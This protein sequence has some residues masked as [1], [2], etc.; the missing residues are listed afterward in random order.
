MVTARDASPT[1]I[2]EWSVFYITIALWLFVPEIRRVIDWRRGGY[3]SISIIAILPLLAS[4]L[5]AIPV[6]AGGAWKRINPRLRT[7]FAVW[8]GVYFYGLVVAL[9][10]GNVVAGGYDFLSVVLPIF[11]GMWLASLGEQRDTI[12]RRVSTALLVLSIPISVYG[13]Y[14]YAVLPIW[15]SLW[16]IAS[17]QTSI[18]PPI[19]YSFR[20]FSTLNSDG[21]CASVLTLTIVM[22]L[23]RLRL[24][25][26]AWY[27]VFALNIVVL[28]LTLVR[29]CWIGLIIGLLVY[30]V[31]ERKRMNSMLGLAAIA[32]VCIGVAAMAPTILG[33][34]FDS[35][36]VVDRFNSFGSLQDDPSAND[37]VDTL[38]VVWDALRNPV[39]DGLGV[40]G[41]A[42]KLSSAD[43]IAAVLDNGY[44]AQL[45]EVG[46]LGFIGF[47]YVLV[48]T[49]GF[50]VL[51]ALRGSPSAAIS[52]AT[53]AVM[54]WIE[55]ASASH[56]GL[57]AFFFGCAIPL[58]F[59]R[60]SVEPVSRSKQFTAPMS[61]VR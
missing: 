28:V 23:W 3:S 21:P 46:V 5:F 24:K 35:K 20:I 47:L 13:L 11:P 60:R 48:S 55:V 56:I 36:G 25:H 52:A 51:N 19:P 45:V 7:I 49:F 54:L 44:I 14:Q 8:F 6:L 42:A 38:S 61:A 50:S 26:A 57:L 32:A 59:E 29:S 18:G 43:Q 1:R 16:M 17:K 33:S 9:L 40:T 12:L 41:V 30:L 37:R 22:N 31:V 39:G 4:A 15:D 10:N 27:P 53:L 34:G 2:L 58:G